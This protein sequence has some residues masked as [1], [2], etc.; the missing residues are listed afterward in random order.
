MSWLFSQALVAEYSA[1][2]CL[3]GEQSAQLSVMPTQHKFW[4]N[5]KTIECSD[6]SRFGLTCAVLTEDHGAAL[7]TSYLADSRAKTSA[8][9]VKAPASQGSGADFGHRWHGLFAKFDP[10]LCSWRTAQFSLLEDL[11]PSLVTWPRSGSMRDGMCFQQ[12][13]LAPTTYETVSGLLPTPTKSWA[14][15]GPGLSNNLDNLRMSLGVTQVCLAIVKAVGWRWPP[16][17]V[18]WMMGWPT[19]WTALQPLEMDKFQEW[20]RQHGGCFPQISHKAAA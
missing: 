5:D 7:L 19:Q 9:P 14:Q 15:R 18:E 2:I 12:P 3:D 6:L 10:A 1:G 13:T 17:F 20:Q 4:R 8:H 11:E 16:S